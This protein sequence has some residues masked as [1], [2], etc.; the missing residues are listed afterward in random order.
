M[1]KLGPSRLPTRHPHYRRGLA[2][3]PLAHMAVSMLILA[4]AAGVAIH[5]IVNLRTRA[6]ERTPAVIEQERLARL[7]KMADRGHVYSQLELAVAYADGVGVGP[8][9]AEAVRW[10]RAA[11]ERGNPAG[12]YRLA[13]AYTLGTG[14]DR[15]FSSAADWMRK[16][17]EQGNAEAQCSYGIFRFFG[18][19]TAQD[20]VDGYRWLARAA[21]AG[22][23]PAA[24][25]LESAAQRMTPDQLAAARQEAPSN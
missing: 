2:N 24:L 11:A 22:S 10:N 23:E 17:A 12:Q 13:R 14:V 5:R 20:M 9:Q 19:G 16:S 15:D 25:A 8:D 21:A 18:V 7:E 4:I 6:A 3:S 1:L